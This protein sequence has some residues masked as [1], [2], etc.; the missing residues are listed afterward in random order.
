MLRTLTVAAMAVAIALGSF[1][2]AAQAGKKGNIAAGIIVGVAATALAISA[3][4]SANSHRN[5]PHY[6]YNHGIGNQENAVAA[7]IHAADWE[8]RRKR[9]GLY[10]RLDAVK[11]IKQKGSRLKVTM[12]VTNFYRNGQR[13]RWVKCHVKHD[14]VVFFK[15]S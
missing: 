7:C 13:Q 8:V 5:S 3:A 6:G 11:T 2:T 1:G 4:Q 9:R 12:L 15:Y 14:R 10:S